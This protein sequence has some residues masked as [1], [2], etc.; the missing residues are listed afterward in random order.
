MNR[1]KSPEKMPGDLHKGH[2]ERLR[3]RFIDSNGR[4]LADHEL[5]ELLLFYTHSQ[6]D[7]NELAHRLIDKCGSLRDVINSSPEKIRSVSGAGKQT[8]LFFEVLTAVNRRVRM[9]KYFSKK[10]T[11]NTLSS[12]GEF[13][14]EHYNG[15]NREELYAMFLDSSMRL[16]DF[17]FIASGSSDGLCFDIKSFA[18]TALDCNAEFVILSHNH[19]AGQAVPSLSDREKTALVEAALSAIGIGLLEHIVVSDV[20]YTPTMQNR[21]RGGRG[22]PNS[23]DE[24]YE[25]ISKFYRE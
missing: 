25:R 3:Q 15:A 21:V 10:L 6:I 24:G 1:Q 14:L 19:P 20:A 11:F 16:I 9:Q 22:D 7:T 23:H 12:V 17:R 5:L 2:R 13:L 8:A 4:E 18:R